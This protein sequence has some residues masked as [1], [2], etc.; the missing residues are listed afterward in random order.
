MNVTLRNVVVTLDWSVEVSRLQNIG[1]IRRGP[2]IGVGGRRAGALEED[3][4]GLSAMVVEEDGK[5]FSA[6]HL[7]V[8]DKHGGSS[9]YA[10]A[11]GRW[12]EIIEHP[13]TW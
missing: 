9:G 4:A 10:Y 5:R 1:R 13:L 2:L 6:F 7:E 8:G 12:S 3:G 11:V